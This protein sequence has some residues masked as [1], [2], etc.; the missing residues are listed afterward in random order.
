MENH[1]LAVLQ[2]PYTGDIL[3]L[4]NRKLK[5][6][7]RRTEY[8]YHN[9]Y[10]S[11]LTDKP[12]TG[13]NKKY[14]RLYDHLSW[15]YNMGNRIYFYFKFGNEYNA[16]SEYLKELEIKDGDKV[17]E[18]S[19]GTGDNLPYLNRNSQFYGID[20]SKGMLN[21]AVKH[22]RKWKIAAHLF[23][24][25]AENLPFQDNSFDV[26]FHIGG[27]NY[28]NDKEKAIREMI[29]VAKPGTKLMIVD[30]TEKCVKQLYQSNPISG[31]FYQDAKAAAAPVE[32][33]PQQM[34]NI[35]VEIV[36]EGLFYC[37]TFRKPQ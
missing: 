21:M 32:F 22:L 10:Y 9:G 37:L 7:S 14:T 30:E 20:I 5:N 26:V 27:I 3:Q 34:E 15:F 4:E 12:L 16:R 23:H 17:L 33:V 35:K 29:R 36:N 6:G 25:E 8:P 18:V 2:D 13:N 1:L 31:A 11:F 19:I 24:C 28:F